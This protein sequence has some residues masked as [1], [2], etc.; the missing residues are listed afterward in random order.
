MRGLAFDRSFLRGALD[1]R[2][3]LSQVDHRDPCGLAFSLHENGVKSVRQRLQPTALSVHNGVEEKHPAAHLVPGDVIVL[4]RGLYVPADAHLLSTEDLTVDESA[5][6]GESVPVTKS[7]TTLDDKHTPLA[8]RT[9]MVYSGSVVT[10]G[11]RRA[12]VV[13]TGLLHA[14][15]CRSEPHSIFD[16][17]PYPR[18][19]YILLAVGG[20]MVL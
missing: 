19:P 16:G 5:L 3:C 8:N 9:N 13:G 14:I 2:P 7:A 10:G 6:T 1:P 17:R 12:V 11:S 15:S 18:N 20:G 4:K